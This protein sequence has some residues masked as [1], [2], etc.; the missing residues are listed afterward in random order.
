MAELGK[1]RGAPESS[2]TL[3]F[4]G[5]SF[6]KTG[7]K[8]T[9]EAYSLNA[10]WLENGAD[11]GASVSEYPVTA[12]VR[13]LKIPEGS[14]SVA[15]G[16]LIFYLG[17]VRERRPLHDVIVYDTSS[18]ALSGSR[19]MQCARVEPRASVMEGKIIVFGGNGDYFAQPWMEAFDLRTQEWTPLASPPFR[20]TC[21]FFMSAFL[22][23]SSEILVDSGW[24][25]EV[26]DGGFRDDSAGA[27]AEDGD[28]D[29]EAAADEEEED[30]VVDGGFRDDSAGAEAEDGDSD[31]EAAADEEEEE[32][33]EC[34]DGKITGGRFLIYR[35]KQNAWAIFDTRGIDSDCCYHEALAVGKTLYWYNDVLI[36][37]DLTTERWYWGPVKGL[38]E[39]GEQRNFT[40]TCHTP[41]LFH[42]ED[43]LFCLV[44]LDDRKHLTGSSYLQRL[45]CTKFQ[46]SKRR[47]FPFSARGHLSASVLSSRCYL[48]HPRTLLGGFVLIWLFIV[49]S[50]TLIAGGDQLV[51]E[52]MDGVAGLAAHRVTED[53]DDDWL[54]ENWLHGGENKRRVKGSPKERKPLRGEESSSQEVKQESP[55]GNVLK[56]CS[57]LTSSLSIKHGR[58]RIVRVPF[59]DRLNV[60]VSIGFLGR[61]DAIDNYIISQ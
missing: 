12:E 50:F 17:G 10:S 7:E 14:T 29:R 27:E 15:V 58:V 31:R 26:V 20:P 13:E 6:S 42:L 45:H 61:V 43:S 37:Y 33:E 47:Y 8:G 19:P 41:R 28:S 18:S 22:H 55:Q 35:I 1:S 32:E 21:Q 39:Q 46:V 2:K 23:D 5:Q 44:W 52:A 4:W 34:G 40:T 48:V 11:D 57:F 51:S 16:S 3:R 59:L 30:E 53:D 36:A 9:I 38:E 24:H 56:Y 25:H 54:D 60:M 49:W